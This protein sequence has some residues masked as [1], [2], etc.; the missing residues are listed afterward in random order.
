MLGGLATNHRTTINEPLSLPVKLINCLLPTVLYPTWGNKMDAL[1]IQ[2]LKNTEVNQK[3][4][5]GLEMQSED[6][7]CVRLLG[8]LRV[9]GRKPRTLSDLRFSS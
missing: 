2:R 3:H 7:C 6:M 9:L 4:R 8:D 5:G 1:A